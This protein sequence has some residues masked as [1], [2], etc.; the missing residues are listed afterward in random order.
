MQEKKLEPLSCPFCGEMPVILP[1]VEDVDAGV[2]GAAY[3]EVRCINMRCPAQPSV[4]DGAEIA[5][6]R[7][8]QA[9]KKL[10][11]ARWNQR[12]TTMY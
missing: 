12:S 2:C 8:S 10:A 4:H 7:G 6:D 1:T 11:I 3:A 9:Y 5:D